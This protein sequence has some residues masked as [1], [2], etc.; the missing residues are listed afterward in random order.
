MLRMFV[1]WLPRWK[2]TS[3]RQSAMPRCL[4]ILEGVHDLGQGQA[5][6]GADSRRCTASGRRRGAASLT[7]TPITGRTF[8]SSA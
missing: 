2:W 7:R 3:C 6:L 8:S 1:I 5:E 4:R